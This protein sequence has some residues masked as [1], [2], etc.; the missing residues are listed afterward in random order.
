VIGNV[1][2]G[3]GLALCSGKAMLDDLCLGIQPLLD[4]LPFGKSNAGPKGDFLVGN[5]GLS[6]KCLPCPADQC[7][8][9]Q[10]ARY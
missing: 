6:G 4:G 8:R 3:W 2:S 7:Q 9:K 10:S 1:G 5:K